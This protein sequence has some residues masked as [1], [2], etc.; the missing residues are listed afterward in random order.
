MISRRVPACSLIRDTRGHTQLAHSTSLL[1]S[2]L[3]T[4]HWSEQVTGISLK[5]RDKEV[6]SSICGGIP[7]TWKRAWVYRGRKDL[8]PIMRSFTKLIVNAIL[9]GR[10]QIYLF[11]SRIALR[12]SYCSKCF[13]SIYFSKQ[14]CEVS[15]ILNLILQTRKLR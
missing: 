13:T 11:T 1:I 5:R 9:T 12:T 3:L 8:G 14:A 10:S 4:F 15:A 6:N 2:H 7:V